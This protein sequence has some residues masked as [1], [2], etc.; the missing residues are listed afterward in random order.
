MQ[1]AQGEGTG[2]MAIQLADDFGKLLAACKEAA[3]AAGCDWL[4]EQLKLAKVIQEVE[5]A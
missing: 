4:R 2:R 1:Q 5:S 3:S